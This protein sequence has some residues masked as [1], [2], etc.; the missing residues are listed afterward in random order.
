MPYKQKKSAAG[1]YWRVLFR[2]VIAAVREAYRLIARENVP[3]LVLIIL[4]VVIVG[5]GMVFLA[6]HKTNGG[7]YDK[8][9]DA[10]YWG[11]V[12]ITTVGYGD[13]FPTTVPGRIFAIIL[14]LTGVVIIS[15]L[16]GT[17]A[18]I[19]VDRKIQE[20]KG[21]Q[22]LALKNHMLVCG[23]NRN[24]EG[25]LEHFLAMQKGGK[26]T[27]V[28]IND[29]AP[30]GFQELKAR[31]SSLELRFVKG[32][33]TNEKVLRR[34]SANLAQSAILVP[35]LSGGKSVED[36]DQRTILAALALKSL[37]P[38][39]VI[40]AE[41]INPDNQQ[42]LL[43]ANVDDILVSGEFSGFLLSHGTAEK[44]IPR[45]VRQILNGTE[46]R[47][48]RQLSVPSAFIG[49]TFFELSEFLLKG[50]KGI[51][52][53]ILSEEKKMNLDDILSD[54]SSSIDAF[55]KRK[56]MEAEIDL[57]E[58]QKSAAQV[59]LSPPADY[60]MRDTDKVFVIS[61]GTEAG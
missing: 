58:E 39:M 41:V 18:S 4:L 35:D 52:V 10:F 12:T 43:R 14:M 25:V 29:M 15:L 27:V 22:E 3:R 9:F 36:A 53:G 2:R 31:F 32:D 30:E 8:F 40:C 47:G 37:N 57:A 7:Q 23:W 61:G 6:E 1:E 59:R 33:F 16:S 46:G 13:K 48:L 50:G 20:G 55:I 17:I 45:I 56:F 19:Y 21:L 11:F 49:K 54:D 44:G 38:D 26:R 42:H 34:G 51:A 28:L 24:T 60:V 5:G